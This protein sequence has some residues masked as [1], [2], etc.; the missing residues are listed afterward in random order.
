MELEDIADTTML[1][2]VITG[3]FN[4]EP[5]EALFGES[6]LHAFRRADA[7]MRSK[8]TLKLY[9]PMWKL[10]ADPQ[11]VIDRRANNLPTLSCP[12]GT[13]LD[14]IW[15]SMIDGVIVSGE[16][17]THPNY[18]LRD[19]H[20]QILTHDLWHHIGREGAHNASPANRKLSA[21]SDHLP[22]AINLEVI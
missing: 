9:N 4:G 3:D 20:L 6:G 21:V 19:E 12:H 14:S 15:H 18:I 2:V 7:A 8:G 11:T 13:F 5:S 16:W 17:L 10:L 22:V 1:P